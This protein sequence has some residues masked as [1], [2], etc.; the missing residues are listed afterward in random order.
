[1]T[2]CQLLDAELAIRSTWQSE[3]QALLNSDCSGR[4]CLF[5]AICAQLVTPAHGM[6]LEV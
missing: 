1:M 3:Q 5:V 2:S 4:C 6:G